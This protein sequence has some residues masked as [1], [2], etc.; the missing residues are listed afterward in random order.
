MRHGM[1]STR[2]E[3]LRYLIGSA[4]RRARSSCI[5]PEQHARDC[6]HE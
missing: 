5:V 4:R 1:D 2:P 6:L 3:M